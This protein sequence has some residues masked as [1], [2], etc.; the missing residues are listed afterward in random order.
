MA[1]NPNPLPP[2][3]QRLTAK[4]LK[5]PAPPPERLNMRPLKLV[6]REANPHVP[7]KTFREIRDYKDDTNDLVSQLLDLKREI[8]IIKEAVRENQHMLH[9]ICENLSLQIENESQKED[10]SV[11]LDELFG[12]QK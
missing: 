11:D 3:V 4:T 1:S 5:R 12:T 2:F 8:K 9:L 10:L 7:P 6:K